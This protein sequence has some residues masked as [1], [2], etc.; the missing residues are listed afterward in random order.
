MVTRDFISVCMPY[1]FCSF[2][3]NFSLLVF[4][5]NCKIITIC[6]AVYCILYSISFQVGYN[7]QP[8]TRMYVISASVINL[9][10]K[11]YIITYMFKI[12]FIGCTHISIHKKTCLLF[13]PNPLYYV[14]C[15]FGSRSSS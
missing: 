9:V 10:L 8:H 5:V 1:E 6:I 12:D 4:M 3:I 14:H 11:L 15:K 7:Y 13:P 2:Y